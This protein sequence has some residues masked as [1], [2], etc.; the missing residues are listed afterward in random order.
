MGTITIVK[1][2]T[3]NDGRDFHFDSNIPNLGDF[4]LKD[5][6]HHSNSITRTVAAGTYSVTEHSSDGWYL[7][8]LS[9]NDDDSTTSLESHR[10]NLSLSAGEHIT[11]T[12]TN[13]KY[14]KIEGA[15]YQ[16]KN[17]NGI[18]DRDENGISGWSISLSNDLTTHT[19]GSGTYEF[20]NLIPGQ[21]TVCEESRDGWYSK[22]QSCQTTTITAGDTDEITFGNYQKATITV[23]KDVVRPDGSPVVDNRNGF[24]FHFSGS[25]EAFIL[26]DQDGGESNYRAFTVDPG[27]YSLA[28][29]PNTN[30]DFAGCKFVDSETILNSLTLSS[31]DNLSVVCTN[32]QKIKPIL[33]LTKSNNASGDKAPGD[34]V[35]YTLVVKLMGSDLT[36]VTVTDLP[37]HGFVYRLGSWTASSHV[38]SEPTYHGPGTWYL[39][40]MHVGDEVTLR[41][42]ADI[43]SSTDSGKYPDLAW[44]QGTSVG[45][46]GTILDNQDTEPVTFVSTSV[47]VNRGE[48]I[49]TNVNIEKTGE[50]LGAATELPATGADNRYIILIGAFA[51]IGLT[52]TFGKKSMKK[53]LTLAI[54]LLGFGLFACPTFAY[55]DPALAVKLT[56]LKS[57]TRYQD[58]KLGFTVLD[59]NNVGVNVS[60]YK[61]S[62]S[63]SN[64]VEFG[65]A[66]NLAVGGS[67]GYCQT[68]SSVIGDRGTYEF[69]V[70]A[71]A[72]NGVEESNHVSLVFD[73]Q[74]PAAPSGY[75]KDHASS[76]RY[77]LHFHTSNNGQ[78]A[79][80]E[81][82]R[83][84]DKTFTADAGSRVGSLDIEAD[85][86]GTYT[87]NL[88]DQCDKDWFYAI[89]A[90]DA[91]GNGSDIA[92]DI[93]TVNTVINQTTAKPTIGAIPVSG[94]VLGKSAVGEVL[95][96]DQVN[97]TPADTS[98]SIP[99]A[100]VSHTSKWIIILLVALALSAAYTIYYVQVTRR[101]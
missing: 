65:A 59:T 84:L 52:L 96:D 71:D 30:Y 44:A 25:E 89:R 12:F 79:R 77:I 61:K 91:A 3:P 31:G 21:Y 56:E 63:D 67:S 98:H 100:S 11:C 40:D 93:I 88:A 54:F 36:N 41:Y 75:S 74:S 55:D 50:V 1:D 16:D 68:N 85:K 23:K 62:P 37:P 24:T 82:Y 19:N 42:T 92:G 26:Y 22:N 80:V 47:S 95:G 28:E 39:G 83:S 101:K 53:L 99:A 69:Y 17:G 43:D 86:D 60:C 29:D 6:G 45:G 76:C 20:D 5:D 48:S 14:G 94:N 27:S 51:F 66:Q 57:P 97:T 2:A 58:Q 9:C 15:K 32:K 81:I 72:G 35:I 46:W 78:T 70:T 64:F 10:A 73:N 49:A 7:S 34:S 38:T 18:R 33:T 8:S 13:T 90:F 4:E 87:D